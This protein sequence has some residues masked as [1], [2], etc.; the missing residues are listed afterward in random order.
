VFVP[1]TGKGLQWGSAIAL[2][3]K[4]GDDGSRWAYVVGNQGSGF[5]STQTLA[6]IPL[7]DLLNLDFSSMEGEQAGL[8]EDDCSNNEEIL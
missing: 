5:F 6:R 1:G 2:D 3:P 4:G 7:K 8:W